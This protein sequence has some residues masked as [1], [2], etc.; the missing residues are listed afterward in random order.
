MTVHQN[1]LDSYKMLVD[2]GALN[3]RELLV[4]EAL[5]HNAP[6]AAW[7]I[8]GLHPGLS[9]SNRSFSEPILTYLKHA[10]VVYEDGG[11][12][13]KDTSRNVTLYSLT[14]KG[15]NGYVAPKAPTKKEWAQL[16]EPLFELQEVMQMRNDPALATIAKLV[17][18]AAHKGFPEDKK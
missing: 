16:Y 2:S 14:G 1:S 5:A 4:C 18:Y 11:I 15:H 10:G 7:Q 13:K 17:A 12:W 6:L 9:A 3:V 8:D